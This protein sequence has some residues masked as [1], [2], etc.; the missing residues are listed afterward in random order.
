MRL[1]RRPGAALAAVLVLQWLAVLWLARDTSADD[2]GT[3]RT[4]VS[5]A[6]L[7]PAALGLV[8]RIARTLAG[9]RFGLWAAGVWALGPFA[10]LPLFDARYRDIYEST[11]LVPLTGL[12]RGDAL[13]TI[14]ALLLAT[15]LCLRGG[16]VGAAGAGLAA[17]AALAFDASTVLFLPGAA[18]CLALGRRRTPLAAFAVALLPGLAV[19]VVRDPTLPSLYGDWATLRD[20][21][22]GIRE[23]FWSVRVLEWLPLAGLLGVA[24]HSPRLAVLLGGWFG[25]Y[26]LARGTDADF[27]IGGATFFSGLLP[28]IPA[29]LL[30]VASVPLLVPRLPPLGELRRLIP[31]RR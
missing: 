2:A 17:S 18:V 24:R 10:A 12:G 14:V 11:F 25:L 21:S 20:N 19:L 5:V 22:N 7:L 28:A 27:T 31:A 13:P 16:P 29:Y 30:L 1:G 23:F 4:A 26:L 15:V 6:V 8:H 3:L 9:P